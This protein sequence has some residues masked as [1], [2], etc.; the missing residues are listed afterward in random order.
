VPTTVLAA[1]WGAKLA[2]WLPPAMLKRGFAV[3]LLLMSAKFYWAAFH[4]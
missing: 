1:P 4:V 2:H 3:F